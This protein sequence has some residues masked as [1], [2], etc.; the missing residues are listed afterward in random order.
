LKMLAESESLA[1]SVGINTVRYRVM[2]MTVGCGLAGV[3]G[4][5]FATYFHILSESS[6]GFMPSF[7]IIMGIVVGGQYSFW[8]PVIG[9]VFLSILPEFMPGH[10]ATIQFMVYAVI[11]M[12]TLFFL[13][14]GL[15][16]LPEVIGRRFTAQSNSSK[17]DDLDDP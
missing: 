16:S 8:G 4:A 7:I 14:K 12:A 1:E 10:K 5:F 17:G 2:V 6:F 3:V 11:V 15:I 13:P 9:A